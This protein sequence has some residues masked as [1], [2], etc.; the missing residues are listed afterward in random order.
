MD[1]AVVQTRMVGTPQGGPL[2]PLLANVLLDEVDKALAIAAAFDGQ[3]TKSAVTSVFGRKFQGYSF[4]VVPGGVT[5]R[6][7]ADKPLKTFKPRGRQLTCRSGRRSRA[8]FRLAQM[9]K[10]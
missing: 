10:A 2:S 1:D 8:Y 7:V 6:K 9:P 5:K 4:C 3:Q